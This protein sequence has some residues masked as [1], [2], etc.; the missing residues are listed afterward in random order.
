MHGIQFI[1]DFRMI[2]HPQ[3]VHF[4]TEVLNYRWD[5]DKQGVKLNRPIDDFNHLIDAMRYSLE[6]HMRPPVYSF[7]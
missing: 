2:V 5:E 4:M 7:Q 1:Q 3:C 6:P